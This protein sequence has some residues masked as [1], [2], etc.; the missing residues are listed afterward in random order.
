MVAQTE[1]SKRTRV[2]KYPL[3]AKRAFE[4]IKEVKG[5]RRAFNRAQVLLTSH[6]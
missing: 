2:G 1:F 4:R 5:L 3:R 6:T